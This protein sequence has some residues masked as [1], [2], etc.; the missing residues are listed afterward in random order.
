MIP[1]PKR[2]APSAR[3]V[4]DAL[5]PSDA[6]GIL[7]ISKRPARCFRTAGKVHDVVLRGTLLIEDEIAIALAELLPVLGC[8]EEAATLAFAA[9][10]RDRTL[11]REDRVQLRAIADDEMVHDA[12]IA[13]LRG[14]LPVVAQSPAIS[15]AT[16]RF[17]AEL[18]S[19]GIVFHLARIAALDAGVCTILSRLLGRTSAIGR[20]PIIAEILHRIRRD[21]SRHVAVARRIALAHGAA[22]ALREAAASSRFG[23]ATIIA[24][25][26][27]AFERLGIDAGTLTR[28]LARLPNGL[29]V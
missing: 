3:F 23:L 5:H 10:A 8:G 27:S 24:R 12:L 18:R 4:P 22:P 13:A 25:E 14:A 17:H 1:A 28:E 11:A 6:G 2:V 20:V 7:P 21:E 16:R 26:S 29:L 19:G 9:L 15:A